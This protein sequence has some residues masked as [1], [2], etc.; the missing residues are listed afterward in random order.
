MVNNNDIRTHYRLSR[1]PFLASLKAKDF[2]IRPCMDSI[3]DG[4]SFAIASGLYYTIIGDVGA[5]KSTALSYALSRLPG[6]RYE[7]VS[8]IGCSASFP[9]VL[10]QLLF[11][12]NSHIKTGQISKLLKCVQDCFSSYRESGRIPLI[13]IDEA[14]LFNNDVFQQL[15]VI[16]QQVPSGQAP[17]PMVLCGQEL[18]FE[19]ISGP[20]CKPLMSRIMDG[21]NI[22]GMGQSECIEYIN[23]HVC[24]LS[25]GSPDI[26][27]EK[28]AVA[29]AQ[30]SAGIPRKINELCL[31]AMRNAM[32]NDRTT[33][34][35]EDVR[36]ANGSWWDR[37]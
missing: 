4:L 12:M 16:S 7:I 32:E 19:R 26:F 20:L 8:I 14:H 2:Y 31:L 37:R 27:D 24:T 21:F 34:L 30:A 9:E 5:G 1:Q 22:A 33:V 17:I 28:A 11:S 18:L 3:S 10:R 15:H 36:R 13:T 6:K 29:I 35:V 25:G 23:H